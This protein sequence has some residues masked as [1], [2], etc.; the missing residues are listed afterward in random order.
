MLDSDTAYE[1]HG[2]SLVHDREVNVSPLNWEKPL[3]ANQCSASVHSKKKTLPQCS[4]TLRLHHPVY[5]SAVSKLSPLESITP[6]S[7][8]PL[9]G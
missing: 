9:I 5:V 2:K 4:S 6:T 8:P 3:L 1:T 7:E